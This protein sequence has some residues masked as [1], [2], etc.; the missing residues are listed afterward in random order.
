MSALVL[1][2]KL[3]RLVIIIGAK[4]EEGRSYHEKSFVEQDQ[5]CKSSEEQGPEDP[6]ALVSDC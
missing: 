4:A 6:S 2:R 1:G 3:E 5:T